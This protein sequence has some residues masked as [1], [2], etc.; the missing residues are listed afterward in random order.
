MAAR[1]IVQK[2]AEN[3]LKYFQ[4]H[5]ASALSNVVASVEELNAAYTEAMTGIEYLMMMDETYFVEYK[6]IERAEY[7]QYTMPPSVYGEVVRLMKQK[8]AAEAYDKIAALI[9]GC[10]TQQEF[11]PRFFRYL[12]YD[13]T[14]QL[15]S[16]FKQYIDED[17]AVVKEL[18]RI[19]IAT[20]QDIEQVKRLLRQLVEQIVENWE[21]KSETADGGRTRREKI[22]AA[23]KSIH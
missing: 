15:L 22:S 18:F 1:N 16:E 19:K 7:D 3:I 17:D 5:Y 9:D 8:K 20:K 10:H 13:I 21:E 11:S 14:G 4:V 12:I 23:I 2:T 6:N